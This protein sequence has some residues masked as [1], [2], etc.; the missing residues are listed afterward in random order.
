MDFLI[1]SIDRAKT[2]TNRK[3]WISNFHENS[4]IWIFTLSTLWNNILKTQISLLQSIYIYNNFIYIYIYIFF[5]FNFKTYIQKQLN[6]FRGRL[7]LNPAVFSILNR[8]MTG[9]VVIDEKSRQLTSYWLQVVC[10]LGGTVFVVILFLRVIW[11]TI[12]YFQSSGNNFNQ[13]GGSFATAQS[14]T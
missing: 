1:I 13:G 4:R 14:V 8:L 10:T 7:I 9:H 5:F 6:N 12:S 11:A 2:S 3:Y